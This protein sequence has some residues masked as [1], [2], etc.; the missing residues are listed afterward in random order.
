M[1]WLATSAWCEIS[2]GSNNKFR[3]LKKL[4]VEVGGNDSCADFEYR[5]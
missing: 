1:K 2:S 5:N 3:V 4:K